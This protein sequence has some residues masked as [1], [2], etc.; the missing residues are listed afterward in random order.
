MCII[1][2]ILIFI[3]ILYM[4]VCVYMYVYGYIYIYIYLWSQLTNGIMLFLEAI[5]CQIKISVPYL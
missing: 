5:G 4:Y 2:S 3:I 1:Y